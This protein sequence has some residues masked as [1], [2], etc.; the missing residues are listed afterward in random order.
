MAGDVRYNNSVH[1][2]LAGMP[3]GAEA[4]GKVMLL[5]SSSEGNQLIYI[6]HKTRK[7]LLTMLIKE[8]PLRIPVNANIRIQTQHFAAPKVWIFH[9]SNDL[10]QTRLR[11][12]SLGKAG[13]VNLEA[14]IDSD[15]VALFRNAGCGG[16]GQRAEKRDVFGAESGCPEVGDCH[17]LVGQECFQSERVG[18]EDWS[19]RRPVWCWVLFRSSGRLGGLFS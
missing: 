15:C 6:I 9:T 1:V 10:T 7:N 4:D 3:F 17:Y 11:P 8:L 12:Q 19:E 13:I 18:L 2:V 5:E 14:V 16:E